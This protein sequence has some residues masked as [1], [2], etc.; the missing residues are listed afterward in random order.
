METNP[1]LHFQPELK[2]KKNAVLKEKKR[3]WKLIELPTYAFGLF[4]IR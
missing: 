4:N 3:A 2:E 1:L